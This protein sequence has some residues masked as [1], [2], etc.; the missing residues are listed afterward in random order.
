[1]K[2]KLAV[3]TSRFPYPLDRGDK[4][5]IY[6]QILVLSENFDIYLF[7]IT[8]EPVTD[9]SLKTMFAFCKEI[10]IHQNKKISNL[11]QL[12]KFTLQ[13]LPWQVAL[14]YSKG[15]HD[16]IKRITQE[17][18]I[19][20]HYCQLIRMAPYMQGLVGKKVLDFMDA[21]GKSM[22][23]RA[24]ISPFLLRPF[25]LRESGVV[26]KYESK[27][28][29]EFSSA[30]IISE[31]DRKEINTAFPLHIVPNGI[32]TNYFKNDGAPKKFDIGFIGNMGYLPNIEAAKFL[33]KKIEPKYREKY[34]E[35]LSILITGARP[36]SSIMAL[37][38]SN[39]AVV[40]WVED[41]RQA[42]ASINI[43]CA[44]IFHS[45]GQQNKILEAMAMKV[46]TITTTKVAEAI[47]A[48]HQVHTLVADDE[49][50]FCEYIH[51][52][53]HHEPL[54]EQISI[55]ARKLVEQNF[56]WH[57]SCTV[58]INLLQS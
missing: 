37:K 13:S 46:P 36:D 17:N 1:M 34:G 29:H 6:H 52:L 33:C 3:Y 55:N 50:S 41:I 12:V 4:L 23:K 26:K 31:N 45:T 9:T 27:I 15:F 20:L 48:I 21:F 7:S 11:F 22:E 10:Y 5:R 14:C 42:Y 56:V 35:D 53:L 28:I 24:K 51:T 30:V 25:Y 43:L 54:R 19:E 2:K 44:P 8:D 49:N 57:E 40:A 38:S 58:L 18:K 39:I 47:Q 16:K 32:D